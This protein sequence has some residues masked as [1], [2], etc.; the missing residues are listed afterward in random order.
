MEFILFVACVPWVILMGG[1]VVYMV[2]SH[3]K[4]MKA[5]DEANVDSVSRLAEI[6]AQ[7]LG[8]I[9]P[10]QELSELP[11]TQ[12]KILQATAGKSGKS[13]IIYPDGEGK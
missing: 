5:I 1:F 4:V 10:H 8:H 13:Y 7:R 2:R 12:E 9:L 11:S 3:K 6:K